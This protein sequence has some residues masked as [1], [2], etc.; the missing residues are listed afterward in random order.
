MAKNG[1]NRDQMARMYAKRHLKTDPGVVAIYYLPAQ[2]PAREIRFIE[3]NNMIIPRDE[4]PVEAIDFG[5]DSGSATEH[6]LLVADVTPSQ[7]K[8]IRENKLRLPE[9]WSLSD[10]KEF[11]RQ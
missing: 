5:V 2:A 6:K 8:K 9:G 1:F 4:N 10:L 3:V 7:W 11:S